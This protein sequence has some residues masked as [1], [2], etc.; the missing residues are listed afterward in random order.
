MAD[1]N[2]GPPGQIIH[3]P[4][5]RSEH[6]ENERS[7]YVYLPPGYD[8]VPD[9]RF[10]VVYLHDGQNVFHDQDSSFGVAWN[11]AGTADRLIHRGR[12]DPVIQVGIA[13]TRDRLSEYAPFP[14]TT[15]NVAEGRIERYAQF[16]MEEIK[17]FID[18]T[19]R[20]QPHREQTAV[21]GSSMGGFATLSLAWKH[22][23]FFRFA[24]ILSPS[25]WWARSRIL[26]ELEAAPQ[27]WMRTMRFWID[28][29]NRESSAKTAL[30][31][32]LQRVRR[33]VQ[34]LDQEGLL[35]GTDYY[36]WEIAG[37]EHNES[38]W[39]ARYDKVLLYFFGKHPGE[40]E[41]IPPRT[42]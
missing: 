26:R 40:E 13:N 32:A 6:L 27:P 21:I 36:Y 42:A 5:F 37:G 29:G 12:I 1:S 14:D 23:Q 34:I 25:L 31:P 20:T 24:G 30:P 17:P 16:L 33:L 35:P 8:D 10:P 7:I 41:A 39:A 3:H 19:Y 22:P 11:A 9:R 4:A 2:H 15:V 18:R 28:M 38:H